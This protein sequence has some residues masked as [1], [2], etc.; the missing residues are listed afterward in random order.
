MYAN[1]TS[2]KFLA[3]CIVMAK[4]QLQ[5]RWWTWCLLPWDKK[6]RQAKRWPSYMRCTPFFFVVVRFI[7]SVFNM[8]LWANCFKWIITWQF[9]NTFHFAAQRNISHMLFLWANR[10]RILGIDCGVWS[11]ITFSL[12]LAMGWMCIQLDRNGNDGHRCA[13]INPSNICALDGNYR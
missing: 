5:M 12:S 11:G 8:I 6:W 4:D 9:V 3:S 13:I 7:R 2:S 1:V 10:L